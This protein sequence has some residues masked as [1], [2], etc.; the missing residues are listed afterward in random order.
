MDLDGNFDDNASFRSITWGNRVLRVQVA[1][2]YIVG[3]LADN[4]IE[5]RNIFNPSGISEQYTIDHQT[6]FVTTCV[7]QNLVKKHRGRLD[8]FIV[9]SKSYTRPNSSAAQPSSGGQEVYT[10]VQ[11]TQ[12]RPDL[13]L[14]SFNERRLFSTCL[15]FVDYLEAYNLRGGVPPTL[16]NRILARKAFYNFIV[17]K[18]HFVT[19]DI[20]N[21][22]MIPFPQVVALFSFIFPE[23]Y[24]HRL[25]Q[26]DFGPLIRDISYFKE[27][28]RI[29]I[30]RYLVA[31]G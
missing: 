20:V 30:Y 24:L 19:K 6:E 25:Q 27:L 14:H 28:K 2:P 10:L 26:S 23:A 15:K 17:R 3:C 5:V 12:R 22:Y 18:R 29:K 7:A 9:V 1:N 4:S 31:G 11:F 13:Q 8:D 16:Y 21:R